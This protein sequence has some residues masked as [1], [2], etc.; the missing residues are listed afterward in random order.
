MAQIVAPLVSIDV[1]G[2]PDTYG[3]MY[4][5]ASFVGF[6]INYLDVPVKGDPVRILPR[7]LTSAN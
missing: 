1:V 2:L 3:L 6:S 5:P 7:A 4:E